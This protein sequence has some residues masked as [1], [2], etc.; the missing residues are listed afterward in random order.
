MIYLQNVAVI[1]E[2][3]YIGLEHAPPNFSVKDKVL[4]PGVSLLVTK[5]AS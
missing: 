2:K 4:G 1:Q 3:L 5:N